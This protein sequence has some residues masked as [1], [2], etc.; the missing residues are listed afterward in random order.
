M[1]HFLEPL[2]AMKPHL[3]GIAGGGT[4][5]AASAGLKGPPTTLPDGTDSLS[6]LRREWLRR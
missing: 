5:G 4:A 6:S 2:L 3:A 1:R